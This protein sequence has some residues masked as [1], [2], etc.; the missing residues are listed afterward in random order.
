MAVIAFRV[1]ASQLLDYAKEGKLAVQRVKHAMDIVMRAARA[2]AQ[3]KIASEFRVRSG[4]LRG[5]SSKMRTK[6][7]VRAAK[8]KGQVTPLPRLLNIFEHGATLAHGR[9]ILRARPVI[10]PAAQSMEA[11]AEREF[12]AVLHEVGR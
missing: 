9:G 1:D 7:S 6:V 12:N 4:S 5:Q 11:I 2:T 8:I 3:H 10:A